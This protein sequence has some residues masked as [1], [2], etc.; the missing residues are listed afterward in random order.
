M[1]NTST[2]STQ[3]LTLFLGQIGNKPFKRLNIRSMNTCRLSL[4]PI[5]PLPTH[6]PLLALLGTPLH[7]PRTMG[8]AMGRAHTTT[9][10][11]VLQ[12]GQAVQAQILTTASRTG[13][14]E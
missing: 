7:H 9:P 4:P 13:K 14:I 8:Q 3:S 5:R 6:L 11:V 2:L 1:I 12:V 10:M